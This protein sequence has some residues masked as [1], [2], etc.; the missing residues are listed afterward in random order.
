LVHNGDVF[1]DIDLPDLVACHCRHA[2]IAT[3]A[4]CD[5]PSL[6]SVTVSPQGTIVDFLGRRGS[7]R[8]GIDSTLTFTGVSVVDPAV[9]NFI[10]RDGPSSIIDAYIDVIDRKPGSIRGYV[11]GENYWIDIGTPASYLQVHKDVL[12]NKRPVAGLGGLQGKRVSRGRGTIVEIGA[13]LTGFVSLGSHCR[14]K[15]G[16]FIENCVVWDNTIVEREIQLS[17]G[18]IDGEWEYRISSREE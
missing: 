11:V 4:L 13:Q 1:S 5:C 15:K 7:G 6:N 12:L 3:L 9:F 8:A 18:V 2:P 16:A 17:N 10:P 14:V